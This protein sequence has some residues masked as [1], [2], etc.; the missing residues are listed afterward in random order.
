MF[1]PASAPVSLEGRPTRR[2]GMA[3]ACFIGMTPI[4]AAA[5]PTAANDP[6]GA[7]TVAPVVV[8]PELKTPPAATITIPTD[9]NS[10]SG[11]F[12]VIWPAQ[13]LAAHNSGHVVLTCEIDRYGLAEWCKVASELPAKFGFGAAAMALR[14]TLKIQPAKGP[15]GPVDQVM[16]IAIEFTAPDLRDRL[17]RGA[18]RRGRCGESNHLRRPV[19]EWQSGLVARRSDLDERRRPGTTSPAPIRRRAAARTA[20]PSPIA[21]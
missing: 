15:D 10:V 17:G 5:A 4:C 11:A 12:A 6:S 19:L 8:P 18:R 16:N 9:S 1:A 7:S 20:T 3:F 21:M 2:L 13:A 14:P